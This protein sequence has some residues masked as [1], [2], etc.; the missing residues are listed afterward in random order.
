MTMDCAIWSLVKES[1]TP[2]GTPCEST[3]VQTRRGLVCKTGFGWMIEARSS[4]DQSWR[5][6]G[7]RRPQRMTARTTDPTAKAAGF[8]KARRQ[9]R[10]MMLDQ[11]LVMLLRQ[12]MCDR[13]ESSPPGHY[14]A[15]TSPR[16]DRFQTRNDFACAI[17]TLEGPSMDL[18]DRHVIIREDRGQS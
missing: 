13:Q 15:S 18:C 8:R 12:R 11:R 2:C 9:I 14:I 5:S 10:G 6:G 3:P 16:Q 17:H 1:D 7:R 4:I